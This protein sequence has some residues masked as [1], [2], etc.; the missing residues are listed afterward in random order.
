MKRLLALCVAVTLL[1]A[2]AT[3]A[4]AHG[5]YTTFLSGNSS[6]QHREYF[7]SDDPSKTGGFVWFS[8]SKLDSG[9]LAVMNQAYQYGKQVKIT[10]GYPYTNEI[11][12]QKA[13]RLKSAEILFTD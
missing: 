6:T 2:A 12:D 8:V 7:K 11:D 9:M 5:P 10:L 3:V 4:L 1:S 13:A